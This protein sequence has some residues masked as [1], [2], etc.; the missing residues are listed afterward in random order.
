MSR[1]KL[2]MK[3]SNALLLATTGQSKLNM[4]LYK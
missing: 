3:V 4:Q 1:Q 2:Q